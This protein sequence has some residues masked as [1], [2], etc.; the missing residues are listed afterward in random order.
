MTESISPSGGGSAERATAV[1]WTLLSG[2]AGK[3]LRG[4]ISTGRA[5]IHATRD[6]GLPS[7]THGQLWSLETSA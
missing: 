3:A 7:M 6:G 1:P 2:V 4:R 5:P